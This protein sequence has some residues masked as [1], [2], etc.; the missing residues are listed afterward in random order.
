MKS[1]Y[2][3]FPSVCLVWVILSILI[4]ALMRL[5]DLIF[6]KKSKFII[7]CPQVSQ[8]LVAI[9]VDT[10]NISCNTARHRLM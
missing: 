5:G 1:N 9:E 6:A 10:C 2:I 3:V 7:A 8:N 4:I